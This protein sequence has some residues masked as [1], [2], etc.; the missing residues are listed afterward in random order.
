MWGRLRA[1]IVK[2]LLAV[3]R[4]PK[5]RAV[6]IGPPLAQL[7]IFA[8]A[9]T[10]EVTNV[11]IAVLN[12]DSGYWGQRLVE[13]IEASPTF[14]HVIRVRGVPQI[15]PLVDDE[16]VLGAIQIGPE[17]SRRIAAG[18][19]ADV[20]IV[21]DGRRSNAAQIVEGY[22]TRIV[23][24][25]QAEA[26]A[27][28]GEAT[29]TGGLVT[30]NWFN[31]NLRYRW[32]TVPSLIGIITL[33]MGMTVTALSVARERELGT[34]DQLLVSPMRPFEILLGKTVPPLLIGL[35]HGTLFIV[36]AVTLFDVPLNGSLLLLYPSLVIFLAAV[37]GIGLFISSLAQTQQQAVLGAFVFA[38]PA[39]MLSGFAAPVENMP[40]WLQILTLADP[41]R[42]FEVIVLGVFLRDMSAAAVWDNTWPLVVIATF[43]LAASSW[44]FRRRMG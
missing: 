3:W 38:A 29:K 9:A 26:A 43:T 7:I 41:L 21:L 40:N 25:L 10:L 22:V 28:H 39:I 15:R 34:F 23:A 12:R 27:R 18:E 44:L 8:F 13:R 14:R 16:K 36:V 37:I 11:N 31:P 20:Q 19:P 2:E 35:G 30:R 1:L 5:S 24:S 17:F 6:L 33:L 32:F 4:D 42:H